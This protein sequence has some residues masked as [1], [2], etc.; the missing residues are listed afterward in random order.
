[1]EYFEQTSEIRPPIGKAGALCFALI[2]LFAILTRYLPAFTSVWWLSLWVYVLI[3]VMGAFMILHR[4][5]WLREKN[6]S[7]RILRLILKSFLIYFCVLITLALA[8]AI[9]SF[10]AIAIGS[11]DV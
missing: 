1:M 6:S 5:P 7:M 4:S 3:P 2:L 11:L 8:A 9:G 10:A